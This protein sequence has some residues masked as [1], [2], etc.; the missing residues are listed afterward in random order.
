MLWGAFL[1][2][3]IFDFMDLWEE[4]DG[5]LLVVAAVGSAYLSCVILFII[6]NDTM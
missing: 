4:Q 5:W 1:I 6:R 3:M 2:F